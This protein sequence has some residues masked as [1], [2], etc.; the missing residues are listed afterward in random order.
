MFAGLDKD[1]VLNLPENSLRTWKDV[2]RV[3]MGKYFPHSK[4]ST[5]RS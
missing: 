2:S 3:F 4:T 1:M 5:L